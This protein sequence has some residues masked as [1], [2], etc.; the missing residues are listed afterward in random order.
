MGLG[1]CLFAVLQPAV[2]GENGMIRLLT[3]R[4]WGRG[5]TMR[6]AGVAVLADAAEII[7]SCLPPFPFPFFF[8]GKGRRHS[9]ELDKQQCDIIWGLF[10]STLHQVVTPNLSIPFF[11]LWKAFLVR[12]LYTQFW[13]KT[14]L[15]LRKQDPARNIKLTQPHWN[16]SGPMDFN[17]MEIWLV[18]CL[19]NPDNHLRWWAVELSKYFT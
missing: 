12:S 10:N 17:R 2:E 16:C 11:G 14:H 1:F 19:D 6:T 18:Q 5:C 7:K 3:C 8:F 4:P 13:R 15:T 9:G